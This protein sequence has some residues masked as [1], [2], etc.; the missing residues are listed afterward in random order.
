MAL[1]E[2]GVPP[3]LQISPGGVPGGYSKR[4]LSDT[5]F[6]IPTH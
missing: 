2:H 3:I 4:Q 6:W 5:M 1:N